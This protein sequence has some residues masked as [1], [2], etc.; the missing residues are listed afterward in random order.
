M[1]AKCAPEDLPVLFLY[2]LDPEWG[3]KDRIAALESNQNMAAALKTAGHPI[4]PLE[5]KDNNLSSLLSGHPAEKLIVFNQ[6]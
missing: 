4:I 5:V 2:D 3:N 1:P 6:C